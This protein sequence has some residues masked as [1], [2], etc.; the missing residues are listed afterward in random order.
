MSTSYFKIY[1]WLILVLCNFGISKSLPLDRD[2]LLDI[3]GYLKDPQNYLHNW[4]ESH[5]PCQFYGVTCDRNSGDVIGISLSNISLSGTISS[6]FSLL[7]QLRNLELGANSISGSI[8]A[9]LA[10]C[11]NLQVLNLS[12]NSLTGQLPDLSALVNLQVL[13][14]ST[15]NFNGAFPT[16]ASKLSGL[17][18]LGLGENSFDEG[19]VPESIGDLKNLT[20]LFLGQCNLR[21][22][23]PASVFDLVS[24]GTLDFSRNQITGVFPK[25]ISKLRNLWKIELYQNNLTGEIP[26][27]LATL[28]LLSEF[29]VSRNQ[30]TGMLPKEIGGLKKLRIFHI[31]HNNFF[32]ELPEELGNLQFLESFS[33]YENQFSGK[34]PANLGR[35]SPLNTIDI[36]ENFFSGEFP[37]F[38]CQNNKLQF[39]LALTNNFSGEFP[40]SYSSCKTLQRFRISQNQFSGS[41]PAGLWGL[42][43]AVIIDVADNGFIGGLSSDI[44]FSVTLNQLYVQNNNFIGELPVELG[45]LTLLQ[46]LVA[47]NNRLS[48]QIPKQIGSLKQLTYLHLEHNALEGSIPPDIGMCSS[49]VD[50]NLAENSLTGDIPD[51]LASLV[52]LNSLNISHNMISGDIPEGLQS[53]KLSDIDF[54]HNELSGPVPPQLLMIAGDYAFSENAGLC[55]ADTSEGWKQSITNL[56]PCQWSDN[57]DNLSRRRLLLV[58]VTV[59]SLVVLLFGLACLSYEN[60][61]LEEF[62]RKGD[63]ESGS[64]T[65]LK[66]VLE[67]FQPPELDPEEI[68]NLDAENLIGCGGTGK[69]YRLELSKGRGTVAVKELWKRD[70]AKLL[71]AEINTLGKIRHRNILKLNAFLTGASNFLVYEY[72]VNGNLYDAIRREFKAGQ[73]ELDWDKR[74]RIAVGVAKGIMYLHHDCSPAIIHRDIKSTNILLDEKYEAKLADFGIA[75][76]V[77]GSTLSC[78]AG[79]HG[80]MAPELAYSL[81]ATEKSDVY[82]FGVV[83]LE[84][85]TGRSPTDQQFDGETDIVSWVSFHLAKQNPAAVLDPKVNNDASDY[86]IKALNI[87]IVCTT[88]LPSERPTMREVVKMLIDI[89][90]SST[91]RRAKNKNDK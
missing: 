64:D 76:L 38:L 5:S 87:A 83:L 34:F 12:M 56:K 81:K 86:M 18:E 29:D 9:A 40:G 45:R 89:D 30:L 75:K 67:T 46:K 78:F 91:A 53:L 11:S 36:S 62:N 55:V 84:L 58:L 72:V 28:T 39:L 73:P 82:S 19:D 51:T 22:E 20:W 88:Q 14:L 37:R 74:C 33:T 35:F 57:R 77:E 43:N 6:S 21:G 31:Y 50:L 4:D 59:I 13:D 61:K 54:S 85:L 80:Y 44:G 8:P 25:A 41:I 10:N 49:M 52:T 27:E 68:C 65:D 66:W 60:Y 15:N 17:T 42:P 47:S 63:I 23:I 16:W 26:Q 48:G 79:T 71:E 7:E 24:L 3:K 1:F 32:G 69:V 2:I 90:P 70:D